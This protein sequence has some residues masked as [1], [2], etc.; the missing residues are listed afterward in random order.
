MGLA[1]SVRFAGFLPDPQFSALLEGALALVFPSLYEGFGLPVLE[2]MARGKPVLCSQATS[3]PEVAGQ[4]AL[5]FDPRKPKDIAAAIER[6]VSDVD[7]RLRLVDAGHSR[8]S[9]L[10][11]AQHMAERYLQVFRDALAHPENS[12]MAGR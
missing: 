6:M 4:A 2:A 8:V 3:L 9:Q 11:N 12:E 10:G 1:A 7:L 5:F